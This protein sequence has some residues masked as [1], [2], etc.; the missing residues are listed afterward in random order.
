GEGYEDWGG[1]VLGAVRRVVG[2]AVRIGTELDPHCHVTELMVE[3]PTRI[4]LYKGF[5]HTDFAERAADLFTLIADAADG[6]TRPRMSLWDCRMIGSYFTTLEPM[7][8]FVDHVKGLEGKQGVL[9]ISPVHG[10]PYADVPGNGTKMLVITDDRPA[11][12]AAL[13]RE[14]GAR[15]IAL[16]GR[17][18]PQML[19]VRQ[20]LTR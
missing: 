11:E 12:G 10:F 5:P 19:R 6:R 3:Q 2:P 4:V 18:H 1:D 20:P 15:L 13:A 8:G 17:T 14:L 9:S 16:R 7:K